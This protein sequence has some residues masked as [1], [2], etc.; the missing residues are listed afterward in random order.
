MLPSSSTSAV[1][2]GW[3]PPNALFRK[4]AIPENKIGEKKKKKRKKKRKENRELQQDAR[5]TDNRPMLRCLEDEAKKRGGGEKAED[6]VGSWRK[7]HTTLVCALAG[8][9]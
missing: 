4:A 5:P 8:V 3:E 1:A 2:D 9:N 6:G 7:L